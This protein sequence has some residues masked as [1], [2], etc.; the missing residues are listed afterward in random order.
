VIVVSGVR[1]E[2]EGGQEKRVKENAPQGSDPYN[3]MRGFD[4]EPAQ[5][6]KMALLTAHRNR[7]VRLDS[8][9]VL[10]QSNQN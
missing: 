7:N 2:R 1:Q 10:G 6:D 4:V 8:L 3:R 9:P 5:V